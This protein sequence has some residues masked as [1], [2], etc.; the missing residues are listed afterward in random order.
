MRLLY[1]YVE[2]LDRDGKE[3]SHRG[4]SRLSLNFST[5]R[6]FSY[7]DNIL[8]MTP[9]T[10]LNPLIPP[11]PPNFFGDRIYNV[12]TFVGDNGAGKTTIL[13]YLIDLLRQFYE[14]R[15]RGSDRGLLV[16]EDQEA[17]D[18]KRTYL[19][20]YGERPL[21]LDHIPDGFECVNLG[22]QSNWILSATKLIYLAN[23]LTPSDLALMGDRPEKTDNR[24]VNLFHFRHEFLYNCSTAS[25]MVE[26]CVNDSK[27]PIKSTVDYLN[28]FFDYEQYK[29][30]KYVFDKRQ[31]GILEELKGKGYPVP[32]PKKLIVELQR[33]DYYNLFSDH[34]NFFQREDIYLETWEERYD[35]L[36]WELCNSCVHTFVKTALLHTEK[37]HHDKYIEYVLSKTRWRLFRYSRE[38]DPK[39][40]F[41]E[42]IMEVKDILSRDNNWQKGKN[43]IETVAGCCIDFFNFVFEEKEHLRQ[44][45]EMEPLVGK[46]VGK[47]E[48]TITFTIKTTGEAAEW[49]ITFLQ[50]YRY[51]CEP[52]Y[53]L[54]FY[55]GLSSGE[56]N[57]LRMFSSLYYI[58][59]ADYNNPKRGGYKIYNKME[60]HRWMSCDSV[61]LWLDEADLTYHPEWQRRFLSILTA[62]L[63][64]LYPKTCCRDIQVFLTTHSPLMLGDF[65]A[66]SVIYLS[67]D[68]QGHVTV[69]DSGSR[70]TFGENLYTLLQNSFD[71]K[72]GAIG[73]LVRIKIQEILKALREVD[74]KLLPN[75]KV[76]REE[77]HRRKNQLQSFKEGTVAFLAD[78]IIKAKLET[79]IDRR[80]QQ[81]EKYE[82]VKRSE[83]ELRC[84]RLSGAELDRWQN[85]IQKEQKRRKEK[86]S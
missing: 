62:F 58:F 21:R 80:L 85:A 61:L 83:E 27:K 2:F 6:R 35:W 72:D 22:E 39:A 32:V 16:V 24:Y 48:K 63:P 25:L 81:L 17:E 56:Q 86:R 15:Y 79:E 55:W 30:V 74:E 9:M 12:T 20:K 49:F 65:P 54:N 71:V 73:E 43:L 66:Q 75:K 51:T 57:L 10:Q 38:D 11:V 59:D 36:T 23:T 64:K 29:Q 60:Q 67:K 46:I 19:L 42:A 18:Q 8:I 34:D 14:G 68:S 31:Y 28:C 84:A 13:H 52:Y 50:K 41:L 82:P 69:D 4:L 78:G 26:N 53:Y 44:Y 3:S 45:F 70:Q 37:E 47:D 7:Q 1:A 40:T 77:F 33:M 76:S 5:N